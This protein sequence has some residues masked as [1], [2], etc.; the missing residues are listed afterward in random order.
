MDSPRPVDPSARPT[1][2]VREQHKR[3]TRRVL[4]DAA[5]RLFAR[6]GFDATTVE[7]IT[8][9]AGVSPRTF[10]RYFASKEQ[11]LSPER[12][13]RQGLLREAVLGVADDGASDLAVAV[14]ALTS[15]AAV[16]EPER[17]AMRLRRR[18]AAS[19]VT[20]R[21]RLQDVLHSWQLA[22]TAALAERRGATEADLAAETAGAVAIALWQQAVQRWASDADG[23]SDLAGHLRAARSALL[24]DRYT[25][26]L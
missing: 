18:A 4:E 17:E 26:H 13:T 14:E 22:L 3:T 23:A 2:G 1:I 11:V 10:F 6:D 7:A 5:L 24:G 21:G 12:E 20:L 9:E 19:S 25:R 16:F 8:A 15:I